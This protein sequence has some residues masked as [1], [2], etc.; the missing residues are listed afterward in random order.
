M[1][2]ITHV[3]KN[4]FASKQFKNIAEKISAFD[5][6]VKNIF[7]VFC[8]KISPTQISF[9]QFYESFTKTLVK[10]NHIWAGKYAVKAALKPLIDKINSH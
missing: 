8:F 3:L 1:L 6:S 4:Y 7:Y 10:M 5:Q 2:R 9:I